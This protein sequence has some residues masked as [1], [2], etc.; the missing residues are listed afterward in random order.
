MDHSKRTFLKGA[1]IA[2]GTG[3]FVAGYSDTLKQVASGIATGSS[4]HPTRDPIHGNSLAVEYRVDER[5]E[6]H[7]NPAQ[8]VANTMCLGCWTLCG[9]RA[10]ID[11]ERDQIVRILGNPYHPLSARHHI[12]FKTPVKQALLATSGYQEGGLDGRSTA[13]ARGNAMLEQ[14]DSPQ[15]VTRCLKRVGPRGSGRWQSIPFEQLVAEV[16]EGGDLFGEG[17]VEGLRAIRNLVEPLD[18]ANPEYGPRANQLLVSNASDEGRDHFI[19]R[20]TFNSFGTRNFANHG[21]YCGLSF[22]V[23]AGALLDDLEK[24]AHLKPDWDESDFLL[25]MGTSPQQ[26]GNPFKRQSRQLAANRA[27]PGKPFSYVVVAPSL[28]NTVNMPSAPANR[29]LPIRPAT[30]S[31][32]AMAMLRWIIDNQR[33]AESFLAAPHAAAA[34]RVGYRGFCNAS[35]LVL[36]DES[37]PRFGQMLRA[38]DL[39]LPFE[40]EAYG[41]GDAMLVEEA[42]SGEPRPAGQCERANLWVDRTIQGPK[43][44]FMVKSSFQLLAEACREHTLAQ[45]SAECAVP[46][47]DI[48]ALAREFTSH[49]TRAAVV[50]H[51]GTMSANGFYSAWAIMM[52]NVM[53]GNLNARGGAVASGGKFDPFGAGPRYD[54]ASFPGMVKPAG[55]FLSRSKFPYEKTSEYRRKR[56][57]GQNPYP[58]RE[59]WF[60]ISGP[61]LGEHLTAAVNGYPY[62]LK[63]WINHMGNPLYGQAGLSKA[64][65]EELKDPAVLPLVVSIDSFINESSAL[66]DY[67]VPDTLTYESWGW[68]TAWHGVMTKVSTG[69][70][71]IVEPRVAKTAEGD[72]VCMESFF[73]AVAKRLGLPG[74]GEGAL[75]G[76]DGKLHALHKA[77]DFSLYGAANVAYLGEPVPPIG[78]EDLAWSGVERILPVLNATLSAEEAGRAAYLFARGGRFEPAAK[79]RDEAGQPSKRWPKPLMVWNPEV[80]SRRHSQS[81]QF[82]SGTPRFFRPQLADGT[83]LNE[84]FKPAQWPLLLTS[85]KS[86]T[87]SS[88]SIGSDRLR[89]VNPSNRVRL[90]VQ[91]AAQ[92]GIE[93]GDRVRVSTPDGSVIGVAECVAGLQA[94]AIAIE[95]GF[96]HK[97]LGA[98]EHWI[99][100]QKVVANPLRGAGVN[101]N[102]LAVLDPSRHGRYPLVDWAIGSSARQG[103]PARVEKLV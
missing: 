11:N 41:E 8:R 100:G 38:S 75:K 68:A 89:Q 22:R 31:A 53:I 48:E 15:R 10:R 86:H 37:H 98:R 88:M 66:S 67:L 62:R 61:L 56:E 1:A 72:P 76:A 74:F 13:C 63:A 49:G 30:D 42:S 24:N 79:G 96:G 94:D 23:G 43:G 91:T 60:P 55:V 28:P 80:G 70:W 71:P 93:S 5:G 65:G 45:Y 40:G 90:N 51:G 84:A 33:F 21:A 92:L 57:A 17:Q 97:E 29:W 101:L 14:L 16:V 52:L 103:L 77:A 4:G 25:F 32:L 58:A 2:G 36:C 35:H 50:S 73:I 47:S 83:P 12:D 7:P 26:S 9:V 20:F 34:E 39:G 44:K 82:L 6:L 46:V 54:L 3:L 99:D 85:Y 59:P 18:P 78:P 69:R 81:G 27:R 102:D 64:I 19:K 95:H 87:M